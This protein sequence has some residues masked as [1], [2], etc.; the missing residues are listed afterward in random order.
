MDSGFPFTDFLKFQPDW[1]ARLLLSRLLEMDRERDGPLLAR[2]WTSRPYS[3][4]AGGEMN[5]G[6]L[7]TARRTIDDLVR[8][9]G[10]GRQKDTTVSVA[11]DIVAAFIEGAQR[12]V[13]RFVG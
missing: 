10:M 1:P 13:W 11:D 12:I 8:D 9:D 4:R 2:S 7:C 5:G 6:Q 3:G